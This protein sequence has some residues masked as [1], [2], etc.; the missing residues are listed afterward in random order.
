MTRYAQTAVLLCWVFTSLCNA[1]EGPIDGCRSVDGLEP[2]CGFKGSEDIDVLPDQKKL[3][4]SQSHVTFSTAGRMYWLPG[5]L[6]LFDTQTRKK[7]ILYPKIPAL[8]VNAETRWGDV[9]CPGE[10]GTALSPHGIHLSR[11]DNGDWQLLVVNHGLRESI[12]MFQIVGT[13]NRPA[14]LWKGCALAPVHAFL[15]DVAALPGDQFVTTVMMDAR[16][17]MTSEAEQAAHGKPAGHVL[18]WTQAGFERVVGSESVLT[19][20]IQTSRDGK[21]MFI[22]TG[23]DGGSVYKIDVKSGEVLN[24]AQVPNPDNLSWTGDGQLLVSGLQKDANPALCMAD[25]SKPCGAAFNVFSIDP[26]T[27]QTTH[28]LSHHGPPM[29]LGTVAVQVGGSLYI[30]SAAGDRIVRL[31]KPR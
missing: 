15:N 22:A 4:V 5:S 19:N 30:G 24:V 7:K 2:I 26:E 14:L 28:L 20:G 17:T 29:G 13:A 8:P 6:A 21:F 27:M 12:E 11:R 9:D 16:S 10:I 1:G 23:K 31:D 25:F 3:I 18:R